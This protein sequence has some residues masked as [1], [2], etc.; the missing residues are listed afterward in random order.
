[1]WHMLLRPGPGSE[2]PRGSVNSVDLENVL[3][4]IDPDGADLM[5]GWLL[6]W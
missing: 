5:H 3:R 2:R 4:D 6:F 1:M